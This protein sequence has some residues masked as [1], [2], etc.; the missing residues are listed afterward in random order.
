MVLVTSA[1]HMPRATAFFRAAGLSVV[2]WPVDYRSTGN[3]PFRFDPVNPP[4]NLLTTTT[5]IR[6]WVALL[7][8]SS[9]GQID[10]I[11]PAGN[12]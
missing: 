5:A 4:E 11:Y 10:S 2:S 12:T 9:L 3:E 1:F 7:I 8:Y 6:E